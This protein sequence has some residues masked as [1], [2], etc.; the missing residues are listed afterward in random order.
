VAVF[1]GIVEEL[2]FRGVVQAATGQVFGGRTGVLLSSILFSSLYLSSLSP[3]Y[4][5]LV[6]L[7]GLYFG[8]CAYTTR[9]LGGVAVAHGLMNIGLIVIWPLLNRNL[10]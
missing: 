8:Y 6:S 4:F 3:S 10:G 2:I 9:S 7:A 1:T 5:L